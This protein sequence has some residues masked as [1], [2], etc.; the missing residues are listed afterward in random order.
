[1]SNYIAVCTPARDQVHTNYCY[2]LVN[3]VAWHTL[4]TEDAISLKLMQG[5]I[6]QNQRA[7]LCL[8]AMREGCTHILFIDSDMTFPQ[9][10]ANGAEL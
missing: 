9:D 7:D 4:N 2:C 6:I 8:D 1:M 5:T 3:M 10:M